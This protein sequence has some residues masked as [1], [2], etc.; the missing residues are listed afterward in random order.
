M[1][2]RDSEHVRRNGCKPKYDKSLTVAREAWSALPASSGWLALG[3][4]LALTL[5]LL[6]ASKAE[7]MLSVAVFWTIHEGVT[8]VAP[9]EYTESRP[10]TP[11]QEVL[12][13]TRM[14]SG[15]NQRQSCERTQSLE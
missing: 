4:G 15:R 1:R 13:T 2:P 10:S 5:A 14:C 7:V 8:A 9:S 12:S 6:V 3:L 11:R